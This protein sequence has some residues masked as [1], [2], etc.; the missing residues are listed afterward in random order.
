MEKKIY[1]KIDEKKILLNLNVNISL[2]FIDQEFPKMANTI[3]VNLV[4]NKDNFYWGWMEKL[5]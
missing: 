4:E 2:N 3:E 1:V 5:I